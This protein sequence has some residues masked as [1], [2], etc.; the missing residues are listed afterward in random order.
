M[1]NGGYNAYY[2]RAKG[3][4][5]FF[6][7]Q[8]TCLGSDAHFRGFY[9]QNNRI[10]DFGTDR[11]CERPNTPKFQTSTKFFYITF[12]QIRLEKIVPHFLTNLRV[13]GLMT[14]NK[15]D[16]TFRFSIQCL[17]QSL[18]E[19]HLPETYPREG[20]DPRPLIPQRGGDL[21]GPQPKQA[22]RFWCRREHKYVFRTEVHLNVQ[23]TPETSACVA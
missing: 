1:K 23:D 18:L 10:S 15:C 21:R 8:K 22:L 12:Y 16:K 3:K 13:E 9:D 2:G 20:R 5:K 7:K 19:Q 6:Y 11:Q 4:A 17:S 14:C